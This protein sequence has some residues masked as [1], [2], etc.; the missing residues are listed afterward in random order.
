MKA[1]VNQIQN[2]FSVQ[3]P[4]ELKKIKIQSKMPAGRKMRRGDTKI[5]PIEAAHLREIQGQ[6]EIDK[7]WS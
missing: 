1:R 3:A 7:N 2:N 6:G 4:I 5:V